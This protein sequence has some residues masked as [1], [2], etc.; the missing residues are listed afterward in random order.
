MIG[1]DQRDGS[2]APRAEA[3]PSSASATMSLEPEVIEL[4]DRP[5]TD[6]IDHG[7]ARRRMALFGIACALAAA[8]IVVAIAPSRTHVLAVPAPTPAPL[9]S[10]P[11]GVSAIAAGDHFTV[12]LSPSGH[13]VAV[14]DQPSGGGLGAVTI[15]DPQ[16]S[17]ITSFAGTDVA[18]IDE[19]QVLVYAASRSNPRLGTVHRRSIDGGADAAVPGSFGGLLGGRGGMIALIDAETDSGAGSSPGFTIWSGGLMPTSETG[20]PL[21]WSQDGTALAV[22]QSSGVVPAATEPGPIGVLSIHW[23]PTPDN[24]PFSGTPSIEE[25]AEFSPLGDYLAAYGPRGDPFL[26]DIVGLLE[27]PGATI[28]F[29]SAVRHIEGWTTDD[30]LVLKT[31]DGELMVWTGVGPAGG[32]LEDLGQREAGSITYGPINGERATVTANPDGSPG[33]QVVVRMNGQTTT[34]RT[35]GVAS[36]TWLPNGSGCLVEGGVAPGSGPDRLY[37]VSLRWQ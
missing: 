28:T 21:A 35:A 16:G 12:R 4:L 22:W 23:E 6:R 9:P 17:R 33:S 20:V 19:N 36:V 7:P 32:T 13:L 15:L 34:F 11:A 5:I 26:V 2:G 1:R 18:W 37:R 14:V 30:Q 31:A 27:A 10:L 24:Q 8:G 3:E 29:P 25:G